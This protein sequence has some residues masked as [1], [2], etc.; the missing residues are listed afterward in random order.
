LDGRDCLLVDDD[1]E[2]LCNAE[3][4]AVTSLLLLSFLT[5]AEE[6]EVTVSDPKHAPWQ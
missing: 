5:T 4:R 1:E 2:N 3:A 6:K